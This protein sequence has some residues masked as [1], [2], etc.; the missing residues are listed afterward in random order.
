[1]SEPLWSDEQL[2]LVAFNVATIYLMDKSAGKATPMTQLIEAAMIEMRDDMQAGLT[3]LENDNDRLRQQVTQLEAQL[4]A[5]QAEYDRLTRQW[6]ADNDE[7]VRLTNA[8]DAAQLAAASQWQPVDD[9]DITS[10][11]SIQDGGETIGVFVG[12]EY[13]DWYATEHLP[14]NVRLCRRTPAAGE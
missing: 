13:S 4:A 10:F 5:Q 7:I 11:L 1:M 12:E 2:R 14:T 3:A 8:L 6:Q 9:G